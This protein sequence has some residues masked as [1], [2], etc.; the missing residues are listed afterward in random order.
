MQ[1]NESAGETFKRICKYVQH[2][3]SKLALFAARCRIGEVLN[4]RARHGAE[5]VGI[6]PGRE[7]SHRSKQRAFVT[8]GFK[9]RSI[10]KRT[11]IGRSF[12]PRQHGREGGSGSGQWPWCLCLDLVS[13]LKQR[14]RPKLRG[15]RILKANAR[16][17]AAGRRYRKRIQESP[18]RGRAHSLR[19]L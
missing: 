17:P 9:T 16:E 1:T 15:R 3:G 7:F 4:P 19:G 2:E 13:S 6:T 8:P 10:R 18:P 14:G 12:E 5:A 11:A